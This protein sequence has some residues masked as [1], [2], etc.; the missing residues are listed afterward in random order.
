MIAFLSFLLFK[1]PPSNFERILWVW[2][3][4]RSMISRSGNH[5]LGVV[6]MMMMLVMMMMMLV[7]YDDGC[8]DGDSGD[9]H[10]DD[11]DD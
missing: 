3:D 2:K 10:D 5:I 6:I 1:I 4:I 9:D 7:E 8:D 11:D